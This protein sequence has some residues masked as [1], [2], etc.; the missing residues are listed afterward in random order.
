MDLHALYQKKVLNQ[1]LALKEF[2]ERKTVLKAFPSKLLIEMADHQGSPM[3]PAVFSKVADLFDTAYFADLRN[4]SIALAAP[5]WEKIIEGFERHPLVN[6]HCVTH[7]QLDQP[8]VWRRLAGLGMMFGVFMRAT[9]EATAKKVA[10]H[11]RLDLL[12]KNMEIVAAELE[13]SRRGQG[14][15][16]MYMIVL[17]QK[18]SFAEMPLFVELA[19]KFGIPEVQF[20]IIPDVKQ[21]ERQFP[22]DGSIVSETLDRAVALGVRATLNDQ[23]LVRSTDPEKIIRASKAPYNVVLNFPPRDILTSP[24]GRQFERDHGWGGIDTKVIERSKVSV[25]QKC[26]KSFHYLHVRADGSIGPCNHLMYPAVV[27]GSL[28]THAFEE[29]WNGEAYQ[30]LRTKLIT[31][32]P[33]DPRCQWCFKHRL[34]D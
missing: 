34:E 21:I 3:S 23:D 4:L 27:M 25:Y 26:F 8:E 12:L 29:I 6:W 11:E 31:R 7:L 16:M 22:I 18:D 17:L 5:G 14:N 10:S 13:H 32:Q 15:G 33:E 20:K 2:A 9:T 28:A 24:E 30:A 19:K 1:E